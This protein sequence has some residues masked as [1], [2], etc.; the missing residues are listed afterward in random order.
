M[1][2]KILL[3]IE[4]IREE[5][6]DLS[7]DIYNNP[8]VAMEEYESSKKLGNFLREKGFEVEENLEGMKTAFKGTIKNGD[9]PKIALC[10]EYDALPYG[11]ACGHHLIGATSIAAGIGIAEALKKYNGEIS[12]IGT[13]AEEIGEGKP[14]LIEKGVFDNYDL[15]MMVHPFADTCI[16]P[17]VTTI[18][19]YDFTFIGKTSHA[20]AKPYEGINALDAV[21]CF[22]NNI[23]VLRQ[24]LKDGT[25]I[26]G[27]ILE[28]GDVVNSIPDRCK[29]RYE[30]RSTETDYYN[31]VA[32]KVINCGKAAAL[33]TGCKLEYNKF[34]RVCLGLK[35]NKTL[36]EIFKRK[37]NEFGIVDNQKQL[38]GGSTDMGDVSHVIPSLHP[39]IKFVENNEDVHTKEFLTS[40]IKPYAFNMLINSAKTLAMTALEILKNPQLVDTM[41]DEHNK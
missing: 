8:E 12:I 36:A 22:Y 41:K 30:I 4:S 13:P 9:G 20:G 35:R 18:G 2:E 25:R 38:C 23:S 5:I 3:K 21:V 29:M 1:K 6:I 31:E 40:S 17:M 24:Q 10:A 27:I 14:Y 33:A 32:E 7:M 26:H 34:E 39:M 37:M 15:A 28:G 11:H 19:G 16:E